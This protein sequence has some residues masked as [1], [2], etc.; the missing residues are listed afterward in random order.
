MKA[1]IVDLALRFDVT[2]G[3]KLDGSVGAPSEVTVSL[4]PCWRKPPVK[5]K[6]VFLYEADDVAYYHIARTT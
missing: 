1:E 5:L 6:L 4:R 2:P 3:F